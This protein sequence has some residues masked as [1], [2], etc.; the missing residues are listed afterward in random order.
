MCTKIRG[1]RVYY[2]LAVA[3]SYFCAF[4]DMSVARGAPS[5]LRMLLRPVRA[6]VLVSSFELPVLG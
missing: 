5:A 2:P 4:I 3:S 6:N 1:S